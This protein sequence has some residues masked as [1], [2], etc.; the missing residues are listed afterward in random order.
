MVS[1]CLSNQNNL[2]GHR[3]MKYLILLIPIIFNL[4][5]AEDIKP[6]NILKDLTG[7][8]SGKGEDR[9]VSKHLEDDIFTIKIK[10]FGDLKLDNKILYR[11]NEFKKSNPLN[12]DKISNSFSLTIWMGERQRFRTITFRTVGL[13]SYKEFSLDKNGTSKLYS[14][15]KD[16]YELIGSGNLS[17]QKSSGSVEIEFNSFKLKSSFESKKVDQVKFDAISIKVDPSIKKVLDSFPGE[18]P[19]PGYFKIDEGKEVLT[20]YGYE[21]RRKSFMKWEI[22]ANEKYKVYIGKGF[23]NE[24]KG[25]WTTGEVKEIPNKSP[26]KAIDFYKNILNE[27]N[28]S[29]LLKEIIKEYSLVKVDLFDVVLYESEKKGISIMLEKGVVNRVTLHNTG[30]TF[31]AFNEAIASDLTVSSSL[32]EFSDYFSKPP[33]K[34][35]NDGDNSWVR[36]DFED[37]SFHISHK[38][39]K[40]IKF[41]TVMSLETRNF[42]D[43][44]NRKK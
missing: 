39:D 5:A 42:I 13:I 15:Q 37:F 27:N 6:D 44:Q 25:S 12:G 33:D 10:M 16:K 17:P 41:I 31:Q 22:Q 26:K 1:S 24:G 36:F 8:W 20:V 3:I 29:N 43:E 23:L 2:K 9:L 4:N 35:E 19:L 40:S 32:K 38:K 7:Y 11:Q 34:N 18:Y 30:K 21:T 28:D 14:R